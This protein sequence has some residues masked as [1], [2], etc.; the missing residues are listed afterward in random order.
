MAHFIVFCCF[1][2]KAS[3]VKSK[4]FSLFTIGLYMIQLSYQPILIDKIK[5]KYIIVRFFSAA[6]FLVRLRN[7]FLEEKKKKVDKE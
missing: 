3:Q 5:V 2:W 7:V 6:F 4:I 1:T